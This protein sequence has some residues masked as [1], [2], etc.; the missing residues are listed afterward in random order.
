MKSRCQQ[1]HS[2]IK[3]SKGECSLVFPAS[4]NC[5]HS[6]VCGSIT[7]ICLHG[8]G[9][10]SSSAFTQSPSASFLHR[11]M[12]LPFGTACIVQN[13][14][15]NLKFLNLITSSASFFWPLKVTFTGSKGWDMNILWGA[16]IQPTTGVSYCTIY[17]KT[18]LKPD[19]LLLHDSLKTKK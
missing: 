5:R 12:W 17:Y 3:G 19:N 14:Q 10:Y 9:A 16:I 7:P 6:L 18:I 2:P 1:G 11:Y 4:G 8:H 15:G 13:N